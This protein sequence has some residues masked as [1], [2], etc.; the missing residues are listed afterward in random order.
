MRTFRATRDARPRRPKLRHAR[1]EGPANAAGAALL[2]PRK[3][4]VNRYRW[5]SINPPAT[6][7]DG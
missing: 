7:L 1:K 6:G 5:L 4:A 2:L 3:G